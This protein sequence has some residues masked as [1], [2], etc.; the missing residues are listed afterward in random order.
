MKIGIDARF[1]GSLGKGLGRYT[2]ELIAQ[3]EKLDKKN[4]YVVFLRQDN[5]NQYQPQA[6]NFRK[7]LAEYQW[8]SWREQLL[9]PFF[10]RKHQLDLMHFPHFNVPLLYR[11]P[12]VVTVHDLILL[13]Y[14]TNR[15]SRLGP[16]TY[17]LK[18]WAY[19][20]VIGSALKRARGILTVSKTTR[21]DIQQ[22][23]PHT[24]RKQI[25][26]T[27][28]ACA[29][30]FR[31]TEAD[32]T[33]QNQP[34]VGPENPFMLYV[35]NAYPHKNLARLIASFQRFRERSHT[36]WNLLL[37]GA[38]DYF[39]ER[40]Q[41]EMAELGLTDGV[42]FF[43]HASDEELTALYREAQFYV[44]PSLCEGFGLPPLEAMCN[45][46]PVTASDASCLPEILG[47]AATYFNA[48]STPD[49]TQAMHRLATDTDLKETLREKGYRQAKRFDW[50]TTARK[51]LE[52]YLR[53]SK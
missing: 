27:Y 25:I 43:G 52:T 21:R 37:V 10:L 15:A 22:H 34:A 12:F 48:K 7:V 26:V 19:R 42:K 35:G 13:Q 16:L 24:E 53:C 41:T 32:D 36:E 46:L 11:R 17:K 33:G 40:L 44:F 38:P 8:Y 45:G 3:L 2:S 4:E 51:T 47:G 49:M 29:A 23:F 1:Y 39:Y 6:K 31:G 20:R 28:G 30:Q 14:P 50:E 5:W 18:F 9:Y